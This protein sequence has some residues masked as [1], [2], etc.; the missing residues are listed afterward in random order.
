MTSVD[1]MDTGD[2]GW[3]FEYDVDASLP[4]LAWVALVRPGIVYAKCGGSVRRGV[5]GFFE[6]T[7]A[8]AADLPAVAASSTTFGSGIVRDGATVVIVPTAHTLEQLFMAPLRNGELLVS[9]SLVATLAATG[10]ELDPGVPYPPI[11]SQIMRGLSRAT[12]EIPTT[13]QPLIGHFFENIAIATDGSRQLRPKPREAPFESFADYRDRLLAITASAFG[14]APGYV[15]KVA[16]SSGYD[17]AGSAA[18]AARVGCSQALTFRTGWAWRGYEGDDDSGEATAA[19]LGMQTEL[20]ERMAYSALDDAPDA[21]FLATGM[22]GEDVVYRSMEP[23]LRRSIL[24]TGYFGGAAW[25]GGD[26]SEMKRVDVSGASLAEF[27]LRN[28]FIHLPLPY[29]GVIQHPSLLRLRASPEMKPYSVGGVYDEP[30]P[31]R[32]AEEAGVPRGSFAVQKRAA[33]HRIHV[34]GVDGLADSSR[35][36]FREFMGGRLPEPRPRRRITGWDRLKLRWA[37]AFRVDHL[38]AGL[39]QRKLDAVMIEPTLGTQLLRWGVAQIA[40]RYES[41]RRWADQLL[42]P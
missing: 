10:R 3:T 6:G 42:S 12:F 1:A 26:R 14:N 39:A 18:V 7:W 27:R 37:H 2:T 15:P 20:F 32:L 28:D 33:S 31:R 41:V 36:S 8:G 35:A 16:L 34:L 19:H 25:R 24:I 30:V 29:I 40:P 21:E 38:V 5:D 22:S 9:N 23:A 4:P 13:T 11:F 17:S